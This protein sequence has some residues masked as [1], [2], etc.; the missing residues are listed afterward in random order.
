MATWAGSVTCR[1]SAQA[2]MPNASTLSTPM[3][4]TVRPAAAKALQR[5]PAS[6]ATGTSTPNC[7]FTA[8]SASK[9]TPQCG[10]P[11]EEQHAHRHQRRDDRAELSPRQGQRQGRRGDGDQD[12]SPGCE[13]AARREQQR[14]GEKPT[15][16]SATNASATDRGRAPAPRQAAAWWGGRRRSRGTAAAGNLARAAALNS[17]DEDVADAAFEREPA[18]ER[19]FRAEP[20]RRIAVAVDEPAEIQGCRD[21]KVDVLQNG[22]SGRLRGRHPACTGRYRVPFPPN[23]PIHCLGRPWLVVLPDAP[24]SSKRARKQCQLA[25]HFRLELQKLMVTGP[26]KRTPTVSS[27]DNG[28]YDLALD[29]ARRPR[30]SG[31]SAMAAMRHG[32]PATARR[33]HVAHDAGDGGPARAWRCACAHRS[34]GAEL[35]LVCGEERRLGSHRL[36]PPACR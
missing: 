14:R 7:G 1:K 32:S 27:L 10:A 6:K 34:D 3:P 18:A 30:S 29:R 26:R 8:I 5:R 20:P 17:S 19:Q 24:F 11:V 2:P 35:A 22:R 15:C 13:K 12:A 9:S 4:A 16:S 31:E 25:G 28:Q 36:R 21:E 33:R 23:P